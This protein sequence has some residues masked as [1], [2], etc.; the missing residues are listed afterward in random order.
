MTGMILFEWDEAKAES[1]RRKHGIDFDDAIEVF[2]DP[3][4]VFEQD[5]VVD[6]ELRWQTIGMAGEVVVLQVS[7]TVTEQ[8]FD[9]VIRIISVRRATRKERRRYGQNYTKSLG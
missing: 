1:N 3:H 2:Y 8:N 7:H 5:R 4:A 6:G 9:E